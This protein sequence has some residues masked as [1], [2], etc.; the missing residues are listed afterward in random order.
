MALGSILIVDTLEYYLVNYSI[1]CYTKWSD[2][3][4]TNLPRKYSNID[5]T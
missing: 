3:N 5:C 1:E 2:L 4:A